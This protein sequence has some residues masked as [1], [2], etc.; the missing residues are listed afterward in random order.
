MKQV[1]G[2]APSGSMG[3]GYNLESFKRAMAAGP[4]F[5]GQDAG[6]TDM[7]PYYHGHDQP[8][9]PLS[10]YRRDLEVM[11]AA[12]R[13]K[14]IPLLIGSAST[15]GSNQTLAL[16]EQMVR[17]VA[18][19]RKLSFR[20]AVIGAEIDKTNLKKKIADGTVAA[21]GP[22]K[23]LTNEMV[24]AAGP[25]V[26]QMGTEPFMHAIVGGADV[27][28]AGRACDDAIFAAIPTLRGCDPGLAL[29]CG[30]ILECAGLSAIPYDLCEP[31]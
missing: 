6:S 24:D 16:M 10:A 8:F 14:R 3:S 31:M 15:N 11:L 4:D 13:E 18:R 17:E 2:V 27:V 1:T 23:D 19:E 20:L 7:G 9:L 26:A 22:D 12:A 28:I 5:I 30:K 29:H 25:I 21:M